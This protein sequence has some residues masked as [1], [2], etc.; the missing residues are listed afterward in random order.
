MK[1]IKRFIVLAC[2]LITA[3]ACTLFATYLKDEFHVVS[4]TLGLLGA[5]TVITTILDP[6]VRGIIRYSLISMGGVFVLLGAIFS[7]LLYGHVDLPIYCI[8]FGALHLV[9]GFIKTFETIDLF[10][11]KNK[12][13]IFFLINVIVEFVLGILVI[14][15][16]HHPVSTH[17]Y[18][19]ATDV[20]Y[21]GIVK[22]INEF[23]ESKQQGDNL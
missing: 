14:I 11:E 8:I 7:A 17:V 15:E 9:S 22:F 16:C 19:L 5:T 12:M 3:I 20:T 10:K 13:A 23:V 1:R 21:E 4:I 2:F 6:K 18:L